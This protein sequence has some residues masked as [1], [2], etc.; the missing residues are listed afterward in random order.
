MEP[1]AA[2]VRREPAWHQKFF[3]AFALIQFHFC[4]SG[5]T[6]KLPAFGLP[7]AQ[8]WLVI[9]N[10]GTGPRVCIVETFIMGNG[11][12]SGPKPNSRRTG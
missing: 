6:V 7:L 5:G 3:D 8:T 10:V 12:F 4:V 11:H 1:W 2:L 9:S